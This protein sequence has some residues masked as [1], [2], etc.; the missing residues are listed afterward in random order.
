[1]L[2]VAFSSE[3]AKQI[4]KDV[5]PLVTSILILIQFDENVQFENLDENWVQKLRK[6]RT[7]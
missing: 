4:L 7:T 6:A 5:L 2:K 3:S 1:M